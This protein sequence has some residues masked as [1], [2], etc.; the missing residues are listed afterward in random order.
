V[1]DAIT[2]HLRLGDLQQ[3]E[4]YFSWFLGLRNL[5]SRHQ[6]VVRPFLL[7][8][9]EKLEGLQTNFVFSHIR[10]AEENSLLEDIFVL[11]MRPFRPLQLPSANVWG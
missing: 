4:I 5:E 9:R 2:E 7:Q 11:L 10:K 3:T 8:T 1:I 6:H